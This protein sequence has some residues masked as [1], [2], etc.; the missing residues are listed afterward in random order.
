[1]EEEE[2]AHTAV[3]KAAETVAD[4]VEAEYT[5][6]LAQETLLREDC[7]TLL[8]PACSTTARSRQKTKQDHS[9]RNS[10]NTLARI[11]DKT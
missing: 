5:T 11:T 9:G 2:E 3:E 10:C 6:N 7:E 1:M 4:E 8:L